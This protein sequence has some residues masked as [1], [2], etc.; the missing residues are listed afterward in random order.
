MRAPQ[1]KSGMSLVELVVY[2]AILSLITFVIM[3]GILQLSSVFGKSRTERRVSLTAETALE[4]MVREIRLAK[5]ITC[6]STTGGTACPVVQSEGINFGALEL[7]SFVSHSSSVDQDKKF[8]CSSS[9]GNCTQI[10]FDPNTA[11][12]SD[13]QQLTPS[14][15]TVTSLTFKKL[16]NPADVAETTGAVRIE[17]TITSGSGN[18]QVTHTYYATAVLRGG[19]AN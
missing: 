18:T 6:L 5:D 4:R 3:N 1:K 10:M 7:D 14:S 15:V 11:V 19:Y 17:M 16:Y 2:I 9:S 8:Y 13:E 12:A